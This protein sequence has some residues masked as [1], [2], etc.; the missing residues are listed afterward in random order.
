MPL[1]KESILGDGEIDLL[2]F[3]FSVLDIEFR[4]SHGWTIALPTS[5]LCPSL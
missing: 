2:F 3:C 1:F 5:E 4:A